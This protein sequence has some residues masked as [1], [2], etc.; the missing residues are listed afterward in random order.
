VVQQKT[1]RPV[2][3]ELLAMILRMLVS[4]LTVVCMALG[5]IALRRTD[6]LQRIFVASDELLDPRGKKLC[7]PLASAALPHLGRTNSDASGAG[8]EAAHS[9]TP[10]RPF[11]RVSPASLPFGGRRAAAHDP[12]PA[13]TGPAPDGAMPP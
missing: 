8:A 10:P 6:R 5:R 1:G 12:L 9:G 7:P 11:W 13:S 4:Y 2:Q 3:F